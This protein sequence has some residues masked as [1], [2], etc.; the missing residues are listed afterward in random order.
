MSQGGKDDDEPSRIVGQGMAE[1]AQTVA[2]E[3]NQW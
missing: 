2:E 1:S 3:V